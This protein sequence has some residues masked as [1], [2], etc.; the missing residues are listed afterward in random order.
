MSPDEETISYKPSPTTLREETVAL[1]LIRKAL[2]LAAS[3][4]TCVRVTPFVPLATLGL[5]VT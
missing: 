5:A 2:E 3:G 4:M 1:P